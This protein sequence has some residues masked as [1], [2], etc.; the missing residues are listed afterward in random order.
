MG[1]EYSREEREVVTA[2]WRAGR[3]PSCPRCS[4]PLTREAVPG[5]PAVSYVRRRSWL[6]CPL[7]GSGVVADDPRDPS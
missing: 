2:A 5:P 4:K 7:C 3:R 6:R 1:T